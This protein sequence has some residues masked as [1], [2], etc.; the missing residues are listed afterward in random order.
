MFVHSFLS[1]IIHQLSPNSAK[2]HEQVM[3]IHLSILDFYVIGHVRSR[4]KFR[5]I[6][7]SSFSDTHSPA[8]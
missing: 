3:N 5:I 2:M 7:G 8:I 4:L 1:T 6:V